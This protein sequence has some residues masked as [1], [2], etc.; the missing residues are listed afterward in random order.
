MG[1]KEYMVMDVKI[2]LLRLLILLNPRFHIKIVYKKAWGE[3]LVFDKPIPTTEERIRLWHHC[4]VRVHWS[5][6]A[7]T[8][9][10]TNACVTGRL[11]IMCTC[12]ITQPNITVREK[13]R[14]N[15]YS[16]KKNKT[17]FVKDWFGTID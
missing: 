12:L 15:I 17:V 5:Y 13:T 10:Y 4:P 14:S 1:V 9:P 3:E 7:G 11:Y 6:P 2:C 8:D 16:K